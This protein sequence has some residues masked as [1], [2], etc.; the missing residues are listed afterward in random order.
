MRDDGTVLASHDE[1][2]S[3]DFTES[4]CTEPGCYTLRMNI[5]SYL[6]RLRNEMTLEGYVNGGR[7][8]TVTGSDTIRFCTTDAGLD[9]A[10]EQNDF[11]LYP[12]PAKPHSQIFVDFAT[13]A[14]RQYFIIDAK[15]TVLSEGRLNDERNAITLPKLAGGIYFM[16]VV[17]N[18]NVAVKRLIIK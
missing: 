17:D 10:T 16:Q 15:G 9:F 2:T 7:V 4:F 8:R 5:S 14:P 13:A 18:E 3:V 12:N 1:L 11:E 6:S